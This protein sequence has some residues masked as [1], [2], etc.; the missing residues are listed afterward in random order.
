[1]LLDKE[2]GAAN[3]T[4]EV[5]SAALLQPVSQAAQ[6]VDVPTWQHLCCLHGSTTHISCLQ[7][8]T[9][10]ECEK[11]LEGLAKPHV[12]YQLHESNGLT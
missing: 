12:I 3:G 5:V 7:L 8:K 9:E 11:L 4:G 6:M 10:H 1:L 2:R